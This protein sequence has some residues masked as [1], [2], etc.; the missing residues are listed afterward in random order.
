[1]TAIKTAFAIGALSIISLI[2]IVIGA[3][4]FFMTNPIGYLSIDVNPSIE[5][6]YNR[7]NRVVQVHGLN[8]EAQNLLKDKKFSGKNIDK[9]TEEI[10]SILLENGYFANGD[11]ALMFSADNSK[12][13]KQLLQRIRNESPKWLKE[14]YKQTTLITQ[15]VEVDDNK[16]EL[17]HKL[18]MSFGKYNLV[19]TL[20]LA[21]DRITIEDLSNATVSEIVQYAKEN[22]LIIIYVSDDDSWIDLIYDDINDDDD[23]ADVDDED[24]DWDVDDDDDSDMDDEDDDADVDDEDDDWDVDDDDDS[25]MDDED[26]D[27][28]VDDDDGSDV[29]DD[30]DSDADDDD[31]NW[32]DDDDDCDWDDDDS[33]DADDDDDSDVDDDDEDSDPD[34]DNDD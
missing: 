18:G 17:A 27:W 33:S 21:D 8:T 30:E 2:L 4:A 29:D 19:M 13:S 7:L 5:L 24:D 14:Y 22:Q 3:G 10:I 23:D 25:D 32:D 26:D 12:T 15:I 11:A 1:M 28:D 16:I 9:A 6:S 34:D 31:C 20:D